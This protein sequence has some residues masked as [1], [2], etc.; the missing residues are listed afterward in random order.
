MKTLTINDLARTEELD[1][2]SMAAVRGGFSMSKTG[3]SLSPSQPG[4]P[5][6]PSFSSVLDISQS[7]QQGQQV[8]NETADGSAFISGVTVHNNTSQFGQN[9]VLV[10]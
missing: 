10:G 4:Y 9:N 1:R 2:G 6:A 5:S 7:L 8:L 3:Y